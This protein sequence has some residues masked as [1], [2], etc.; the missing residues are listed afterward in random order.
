MWVSRSGK[1]LSWCLTAIHCFFLLFTT[2]NS[3]KRPFFPGEPGSVGSLLDPPF[4]PVMKENL[5]VSVELFFNCL[6]VLHATKP[7]SVVAQMVTQCT[8]PNQWP[9]A[10]SFLYPQL[11]GALPVAILTEHETVS[12]YNNLKSAGIEC[13]IPV[14]I[15]NFCLFLMNIC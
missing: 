10:E 1:E 7:S 15:L 4:P 5:W 14:I 6:D 8:N 9:V 3:V 13:G 11:E 2:T 12:L